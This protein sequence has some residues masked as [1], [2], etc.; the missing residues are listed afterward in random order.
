MNLLDIFCSVNNAPPPTH[1]HKHTCSNEN[2]KLINFAYPSMCVCVWGGGW[3]GFELVVVG[4]GLEGELTEKIQCY[5][6][7]KQRIQYIKT[8]L[9][10]M[11]CNRGDR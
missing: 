8:M 6:L 2:F 9:Q 10:Q 5:F 7:E 11:W 4:G 3:R 1:T